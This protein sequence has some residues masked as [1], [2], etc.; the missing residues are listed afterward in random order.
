MFRLSS[1]SRCALC[2]VLGVLAVFLLVHQDQL[3][4][5]LLGPVQEWLGLD[6]TGA[7]RTAKLEVTRKLV[8]ARTRARRDIA[9]ALAEGRLSL[10]EAGERLREIDL[11][12]PVFRWQDFRAFF[13]G[14][15]DEERFC[16]K[17]IAHAEGYLVNQPEQALALRIR[18]EEE[19]RQAVRR[20]PLRSPAATKE[21][22]GGP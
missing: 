19:L 9:L 21:E 6:P 17:A 5:R 3:S 15:S 11:S 22:E 14:D 2:A 8:L 16:R 10:P 7:E 20:G 13:P 18:L 12:G 4:V 1:G